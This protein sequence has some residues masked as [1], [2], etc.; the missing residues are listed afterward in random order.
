MCCLEPLSCSSAGCDFEGKVS[1]HLLSVKLQ[2]TISYK[3][4]FS[5]IF[6]RAYMCNSCN[7]QNV[8]VERKEV[9]C[10]ILHSLIEVPAFRRFHKN[11]E[12]DY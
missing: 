1:D 7:V 3:Q 6:G 11:E 12:S 2:T 8:C 9:T 10:N 4:T 5:L